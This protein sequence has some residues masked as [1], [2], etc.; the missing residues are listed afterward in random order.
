MITARAWVIMAHMQPS[1]HAWGK[2]IACHLPSVGHID[3]PWDMQPACHVLVIT[4]TTS[5]KQGAGRGAG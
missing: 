4:F 2:Q 1:C 3:T 5:F